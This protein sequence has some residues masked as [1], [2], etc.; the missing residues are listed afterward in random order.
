M[1]RHQVIERLGLGRMVETEIAPGSDGRSVFIEIHPQIDR[2]KAEL[3][4]IGHGIEPLLVRTHANADVIQAY[5]VRY[6]SLNPG[7]ESEPNDWDHY[8]HERCRASYASLD[9]LDAALRSRFGLSLESFVA[10]GNT[11][12][13]L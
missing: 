12:S 11:A 1:N 13:P 9:A 5:E 4:H 2:Q 8:L 3:R 10:R 6:C 7:W